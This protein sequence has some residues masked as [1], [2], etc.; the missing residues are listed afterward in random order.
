[1]NKQATYVIVTPYD[2]TAAH[3]K[4][5]IESRLTRLREDGSQEALSFISNTG[6]ASL[7][8][9]IYLVFSYK[10]E[11]R[12][13][14]KAVYMSYPNLYKLKAVMREVKDLLLDE[15]TFTNANGIMEVKEEFKEPIVYANIGKE[16]KWLSFT[17]CMLSGGDDL[18]QEKGVTIH[19]PG[20][21][22]VS[23]L[24]AD[25]FMNIFEIVE[26]TNLLELQT[27][28]GCFQLI[29]NAGASMPQASYGGYNNYQN[30]GGYQQGGGYGSAPQ[31]PRYNNYGRTPSSSGQQSGGYPQ[32]RVGYTG[33]QNQYNPARDEAHQQNN[34]GGYSAPQR[35][36]SQNQTMPP[37]N[38]RAPLISG[39]AVDQV[40]VSKVNWDSDADVDSIFDN[41]D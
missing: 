25:E 20:N 5:T 23:V 27:I 1:M 41:N 19:I 30:N 32:R 4:V 9:N 35:V 7:N 36:P 2:S 29:N 17:I 39:D 21:D 18:S 3:F 24:T 33:N 34:S 26:E 11:S 13:E 6:R 12:E 38:D 10:G 31:A 28:I 14:S 22:Y 37:R 16:K 40:P 8:P 15:N